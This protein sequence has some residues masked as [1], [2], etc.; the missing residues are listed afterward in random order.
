MEWWRLTW[1]DPNV[2]VAGHYI[3][4]NKTPDDDHGI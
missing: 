4:F 1:H 3:P 2:Y